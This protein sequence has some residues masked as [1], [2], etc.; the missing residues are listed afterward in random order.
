MAQKYKEV[1]VRFAPSPTGIPHI[2]SIRTALYNYLFA[3]VNKGKF[4]LRIE[5]TDQKRFVKEAE[6]AILNSL[7][8]LTLNWD[9]E[10][11][12]QSKR[13]DI[14]KKYT[15]E[16]LDKKIAYEKDGAVWVKMPDNKTFSWTDLVGNKKISF[17]GKD[18]KDFV[19]L[20]SDGFPTYHLANVVDDHLMEITHVIRGE[21]WIS[22]VPKHLFLYESFSWQ[23]P[24]FAHMPVILGPDKGKL[25]KRHGA[26]SALDYKNDGYLKE[27]ILNFI[28]ILGWNP[29]DDREILSLEEMVKLFNLKDVNT[30]NPK[31][32]AV[33]LE[34]MNG[35]WIRNLENLELKKR[36]L[37]FDL[38][39]GKEIEEKYL[40]GFI[41]ITK[42]RIKTLR[43][44]KQMVIP[45]I[46][47]ANLKLTSEEVEFKK[48]LEKG[49]GEVKIW[50]REEVS[51][52][53]SA[54]LL[55]EGKRF[56]FLYKVLIGVDKGLPITD[57]L[58]VIGKEKTLELFKES[59]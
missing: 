2:G 41:E 18:Q 27:A 21:E 55:K 44:F 37:E 5:D 51:N 33:K 23:A 19:I 17:D 1:K 57:S 32:D 53:I 24:Y 50:N 7:K 40:D 56:P 11:I 39:I 4:L 58:V 49:L 29:G 12:H 46:K 54:F 15:K 48:R 30:A 8:W 13:L 28:A 25:S 38:S 26:K 36:L 16:L 35:M 10:I 59:K 14:Y 42:T 9:L 6:E 20:K 22:S 31:F 43:E 34:W 3:R 47:P 52:F 45:F